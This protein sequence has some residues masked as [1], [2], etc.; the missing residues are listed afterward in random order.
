[1]QF[2]LENTTILWRP[3]EAIFY[4]TFVQFSL[5]NTTI[6]W[7]PHEGYKV[8][9]PAG[10]R[11]LTEN[12]AGCE[13]Q[14]E[15]RGGRPRWCSRCGRRTSGETTL[16]HP[17]PPLAAICARSTSTGRL[18]GGRA[19]TGGIE[20]RAAGQQ[21]FF[22]GV[23][24][25]GAGW[26]RRSHSCGKEQGGGGSCSSCVGVSVWGDIR[27]GA[28]GGGGGRAVVCAGGRV[29]AQSCVSERRRLRRAVR[30]A[31]GAR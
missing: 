14:E 16:S 10:C 1:M 15:R 17:P 25:G 12:R 13:G 27:V 18:A 30:A 26:R 31:T 29:K 6:L 4:S 3:H 11:I 9:E 5:E 22:R 8:A 23:T 7:H 19:P 2:A 20:L 21:R 24:E 28:E